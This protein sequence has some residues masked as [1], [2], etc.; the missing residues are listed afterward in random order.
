M[1]SL[2]PLSF[3]VMGYAEEE[4][5]VQYHRSQ[6]KEGVDQ[7]EVHLSNRNAK[8]MIESQTDTM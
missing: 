5:E 1:L 6:G 3:G 4:E 7:F 8:R 2:I